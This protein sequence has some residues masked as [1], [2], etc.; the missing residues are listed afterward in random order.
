MTAPTRSRPTSGE[1]DRPARGFTLI[2]VL[3]VV[4]IIGILAAIAYPSYS[5][6]VQKTRRTDA[7]L[8]L[9]QARQALERCRSTTYTYVDCDLPNSGNSVEGDY[10]LALTG[11]TTASSFTITATAKSGG[12]QAGDTDCATLTID[13]KDQPKGANAAG[14][15]NPDCWN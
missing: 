2:E 1:H 3:I 5:S 11:T 4:A 12:R 13:E 8:S 9:L 10:T 7:H 6:Y 14:T 15:N